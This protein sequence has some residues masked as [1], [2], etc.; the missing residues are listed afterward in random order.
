[1]CDF[2]KIHFIRK[3]ISL[4]FDKHLSN[5][6]F[7]LFFFLM[8]QHYSVSYAMQPA[9]ELVEQQSARRSVVKNRGE[10]SNILAREDEE[11]IPL[12]PTAR[13]KNKNW[14]QNWFV[15]NV[16]VEVPIIGD[17]F[18]DDLSVLCSIKRAGKSTAMLLGGSVGMMLDF[19]PASPNDNMAT[20]IAKN[21]VNMAIGMGAAAITHNIVFS[22]GEVIYQCVAT[23][24]R[25]PQ[26]TQGL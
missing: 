13:E 4:F 17:F 15:K 8:F 7:I 19:I 20:H 9:D 25:S 12:L 1:M 23:P 10:G 5:R 6:F 24:H 11:A 18:H 26:E 3:Y 22:L 2:A 14:K 16:I 21:S